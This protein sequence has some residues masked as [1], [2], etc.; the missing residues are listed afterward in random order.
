MSGPEPFP[1][2]PLGRPIRVLL[3][4]GPALER[5]PVRFSVLLDRHPQVELVGGICETAGLSAG[6]RISD[7]VR[8]RRILAPA[9]LA[10][11]L[12][13]AALRTATSPVQELRWQRERRALAQ[14]LLITPDLHQPEV[15]EWVRDTDPDLALSYGGPILR[16]ELFRIPR[17]GTLGIHHGR[18]PDYRG[19]KTTFWALL[20]DEERAGV[21]IQ[22]ITEGLD[23]GPVVKSGE[24]LARGRSRGRVFRQLE[25]LGLDLY[26]QAVLA[27][28]SGTARTRQVA[29]LPGPL[30]RDP[31]PVDLLRYGAKRCRELASSVRSDPGPTLGGRAGL[32]LL[33]ES[34]H[35]MV[36]GGETQARALAAELS[37]RG[38][39]VVAATR[40]WEPHAP[41]L[42]A[43]DGTLVHRLAPSGQGHLKK[44]G[45]V[46]TVPRVIRRHR[47]SHP[48]VFVQGFR[49]LGIPAMLTPGRRRRQVILKAD[50]MGEMSG[51][52]FAPGLRRLGLSTRFLP[53][54]LALRLRN[55]TLRRADAFVAI[56]SAVADELV[57]CGV[58]RERIHR[59][60][61]GIDLQRFRPPRTG[62]KVAERRFLELPEAAR[63]VLYTG[64][65]VS[66]KGLPLLLDVWSRLAGR[67]PRA[68]LVLVGEGGADI[69]SCE[70]ELRA[71]VEGGPGRAPI[72]RVHF[73]GAVQ[74]VERFL[75]VADIFVFPSESESFGISVA[76]AMAAGLPVVAT[77]AG[78]LADLVSDEWGGI[79]VPVGDGQALEEALHRL[80]SEPELAVELGRRGVRTARA[81]FGMEAVGAAYMDLLAVLMPSF[82]SP[83]SLS[84]DGGPS[85]IGVPGGSTGSDFRSS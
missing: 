74:E 41:S 9:V 35:P 58:P 45:L 4:C 81:R 14:R 70:A 34:Y 66:Y 57:E 54:R 59:I 43:V 23:A 3:I 8:R 53:V 85:R 19:K 73:A 24:V 56:S 77:R 18:L 67:H 13:T 82:G 80:L 29:G 31:G 61:N 83:S 79:P 50:S 28:A 39:P 7:L 11:G 69:H 33:T 12:L 75:K 30:Y 38:V 55:R 72:P 10:A 15:L 1:K 46:L 60:P 68:H 71:R 51:A 48:I 62:E 84:R 65:L 22:K 64:R 49:I 27:V 37:R 17:F 44:W 25:D 26:L 40:R 76:E 78:G 6:K 32:L 63:I 36:G 47:A 16:P 21:T 2:A 20:N 5:G 52:F 42:G